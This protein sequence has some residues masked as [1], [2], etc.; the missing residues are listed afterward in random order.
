VTDPEVQRLRDEISAVDRRVLDDVNARVALVEELKRVKE[1]LGLGF[2]D[3]D[4]ERAVVEGLVEAN[5]GPLTDDG[6]R[7]LVRDVL[8][9]TK[10]EV[11][12]RDSAAS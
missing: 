7:E 8:D 3:A 11:G 2:V 10:R 6:V 9:L 1:R 4:R 12:R 5:R